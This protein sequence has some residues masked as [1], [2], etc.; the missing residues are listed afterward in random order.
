MKQLYTR[1]G[2]NLDSEHVLQEYPRPALIRDT[3]Y[4]IL[5]GEWEYAFTEIQENPKAYDGKIL[6]PFSPECVLSGVGRQLKPGEYLWYR[7]E[8]T[9]DNRKLKDGIEKDGREKGHILIHFGAIDQICKVFVN[10]VQVTEHISGYLPFSADITD[11]IH[12]GA[13]ELTVMVQDYSDTSYHARGKQKLE[14][15]GMFYTAQSGIWQTVWLEYVPVKWIEGVETRIKKNTKNEKSE[16]N[17]EPG[18]E[19]L[20][21]RVESNNLNEK[22]PIKIEIRF[23]EIYSD[24]DRNM[25][26]I[27]SFSRI[28]PEIMRTVQG[29]TNTWIEI[30]MPKPKYWNCEEPYLYYMHVT[31]CEHSHESACMDEVESYFAIRKFEIKND[32]HNTP[33]ICLNGMEHFQKGVLDQGYWPDGLYTAPSDE[34]LIFDIREMK[35]TGFNMVRKHI[36]IEPERWYY[37][38][39]RLGMIVWQDMINGGEQY[40]HWFVTYLA[41]VMS[42]PGITMKDTHSRLLSRCNQDGRNEFICEVKETVKLLSNHPSICTW[43]I[44]NEGWGQFETRR[45]T[46]MVRELDHERLIDSASGWFDQGTGDFQS[47]HNY[48]FPLKVKPEKKRASVLSEYGGFTFGVGGHLTSEKKYGY[49]G[50][51]TETEYKKAYE[52]LEEKMM[53]LKEQGLCGCIYTQWSDIEDEINGVYTYDREINKLGSNISDMR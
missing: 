1:W 40:H 39:D 9:V 33:R 46:D 8:I 15:G 4:E 26:E 24:P 17:Q 23:P 48:F 7:K 36:K 45:I 12:S 30:E 18:I 3:D 29:K 41:N 47:V 28:L 34:A 51:K 10:G 32:R 35:N 52:Q 25:Q 20:E 42:W 49:G 5:N 22:I 44:F 38:C 21:M 14:R 37:H 13:N 27:D 53:Y 11:Y 6:V 50:C 31:M 2:M 43:V 19:K 16:E